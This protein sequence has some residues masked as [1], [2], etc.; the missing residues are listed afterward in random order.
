MFELRQM[1]LKQVPFGRFGQP[2][3]VTKAAA[4]LAAEWSDWVTGH[5][6]FVD[7]GMHLIGEESYI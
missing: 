7:G 5:T 2:E 1:H 3:D 6:L 4:F